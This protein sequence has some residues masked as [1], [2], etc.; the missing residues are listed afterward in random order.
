MELDKMDEKDKLYS[1]KNEEKAIVLDYMPSGKASALKSEPIA[2][3]IGKEYFTLLEVTPK[4]GSGF[5]IGEEVLIGKENRNKVELIKGRISFKDLT[6]NS[7]SELSDTIEDI[8]NENEKKYVTFFN[9]ARAISLKRHQLELLPGIGKK[10]MLDV[11]KEREKK[12]FENFSDLI[13]RVKSV[14]DPKKAV[15]KRI[16]EELEGIEDKHYIFVRPPSIP[17][18]YF[19]SNKRY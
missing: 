1:P 13:A 3:V 14:P 7:L 6:S 8:I 4:I 10:H 17:K 15:V 12:L 11:L 16:M 18:P 9:N 19:Y 5:S 2:Q